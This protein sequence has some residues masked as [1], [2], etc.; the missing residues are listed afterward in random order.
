MRVDHLQSTS[1]GAGTI[2]V[3]SRYAVGRPARCHLH[4]RL[5]LLAEPRRGGWAQT[6]P[7]G[8][9]DGLGTRALDRWLD[10]NRGLI[11]RGGRGFRDDCGAS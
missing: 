9:E 11:G 10:Q 8:P 4:R 3:A 7:A 6:P 2:R 5:S 1:G